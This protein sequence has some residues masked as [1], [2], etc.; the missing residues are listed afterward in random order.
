MPSFCRPMELSMLDAHS[1]IR[2]GGFP[3]RGLSVTVFATRAPKLLRSIKLLYSRPEPNVPDAGIT[4]LFIFIPARLT[5]RFTLILFSVN[6][7]LSLLPGVFVI[8]V[9]LFFVQ[10]GPL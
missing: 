10:N 8:F 4:G 1:Q 6:T 3:R 2:G 9:K 7:L 5:L